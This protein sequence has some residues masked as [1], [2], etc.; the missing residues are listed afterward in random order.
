M[1]RHPERRPIA[2]GHH[3]HMTN[4]NNGWNIGR[5]G[6]TWTGPE[7]LEKLDRLPGRLELVTCVRNL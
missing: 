6:L 7:G 3:T 4:E 2:H 1:T 5:A